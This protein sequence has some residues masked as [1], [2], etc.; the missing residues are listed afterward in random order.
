M[1]RHRQLLAC[2]ALVICS[3][4]AVAAQQAFTKP[5]SGKLIRLEIQLPGDR[6]IKG[7]VEEGGLFKI[8]DRALGGTVVGFVP[9][10]K[11][12][13]V[14]VKVYEITKH[15]SGAGEVMRFR[16]QLEI[17]AGAAS[18]TRKVGRA[19][20]VRVLGIVAPDKTG[21]PSPKNN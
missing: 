20:E 16:E 8:K 5:I 10:V 7:V 19:F 11:G 13:S 12:D 2:C 18:I 9:V 14:T 21:A 15:P 17:G 6:A 4:G 3:V 1:S